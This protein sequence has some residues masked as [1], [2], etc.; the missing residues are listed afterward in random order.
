MKKTREIKFDKVCSFRVKRI[1]LNKTL[2]MFKYKILTKQDKA[3]PNM[4]WVILKLLK[5]I[6]E[7]REKLKTKKRIHFI[8]SW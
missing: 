1:E 6:N 2:N 4:E 7:N 3:V 5:A 8:R